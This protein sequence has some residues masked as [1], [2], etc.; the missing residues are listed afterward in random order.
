ME[1]AR[2][3]KEVT[4]V[5]GGDIVTSKTK[6]GMISDGWIAIRDGKIS[7]IGRGDFGKETAGEKVNT[8]DARGKLV[9]PGF[10][11]CHT[12]L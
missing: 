10:L 5:R 12:H 3:R 11:N 4:V 7:R 2:T 8:V 6:K 9:L 1:R